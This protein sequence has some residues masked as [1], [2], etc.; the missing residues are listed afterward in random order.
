MKWCP[1]LILAP[2]INAS[3]APVIGIDVGNEYMKIAAIAPGHNLEM[4]LN[5]QSKRKTRS[6]VSFVGAVREF[7]ENAYAQQT[8]HPQHVAQF[9]ASNIAL[10]SQDLDKVKE[11]PNG[12][13]HKYYP[14]SLDKDQEKR[15]TLKMSVHPKENTTLYMEE[16]LA[17][18]LNHGKDLMRTHLKDLSG[19]EDHKDDIEATF[20]IPIH[21]TYRQRQLL[22][23][24]AQIAGFR[25]LAFVYAPMS[26]AL[27]HALDIMDHLDKNSTQ[28]NIFLDSGSRHLQ[29][30]LVKYSYVPA[31]E[32]SKAGIGKQTSKVTDILMVEQLGC[33]TPVS[34]D[35]RYGAHQLDIILADAVVKKSKET[36][37]TARSFRRLLKDVGKL[38]HTLSTNKDSSVNIGEET[39][40]TMTRTEFESLME[41][42]NWLHG[43]GKLKEAI[44]N[45]WK[46]SG[47]PALPME[48]AVHS[49][50]LI[51]GGWR[52]PRVYT[53]IENKFAPLPLGQKV[54]GDESMALGAAMIAANHSTTYKF[55]PLILT[56][57]LNED[58]HVDIFYEDMEGQ[59]QRIDVSF[60]KGTRFGAS[61]KR[62]LNATS[63][64]VKVVVSD[65]NMKVLDMWTIEGID[66]VEKIQLASQAK[67]ERQQALYRNLTKEYQG[68][69]DDL[70]PTW[71]SLDEAEKA[72][73]EK[74]IKIVVTVKLSPLGL[75]QV[76]K[77][78]AGWDELLAEEKD[79]KIASK[80]ANDGSS[81]TDKESENLSET[82]TSTSTQPHAT[83][84][85]GSTVSNG[86]D[87]S[88]P[89]ANESSTSSSTTTS[90]T[91]K[92]TRKIFTERVEKRS[93]HLTSQ[94]MDLLMKDMSTQDL[95]KIQEPLPFNSRQLRDA[96]SALKNF[97]KR[98]LDIEKLNEAR[99]RLEASIYEERERLRSN[100]FIQRVTTKDEREALLKSLGEDEE[101][102]YEEGFNANISVVN[103]RKKDLEN[104]LAK[105]TSKALEVKQREEVIEES[106][107]DIKDM[108]QK[109]SQAQITKPWLTD[110]QISAAKQSLIEFEAWFVEAREKQ[111]KLD[112]TADSVLTK[113]TVRNEWTKVTSSWQKLMKIR[114]PK[115]A[116]TTKGPDD[117]SSSAS[118]RQEL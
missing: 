13:S 50:E 108:N 99:N 71:N 54:N 88:T 36:K 92:R 45:L 40:V 81:T 106:L 84:T 95:E 66:V 3:L 43:I 7:G 9:F 4:I 87:G 69:D 38:K 79:E 118:Q 41:A 23:Q 75:V 83:N 10:K 58:L 82:S 46:S 90:T 57:L 116:A 86:A 47:D 34:E 24:A 6:V 25:T 55:R 11:K 60:E 73:I 96:K 107:R 52:A 102:L 28:H 2:L 17:H 117:T 44:S 100:E 53:E 15:S 26:A 110:A 14:Y 56:Q 111:S 113:E 115:P 112:D 104:R 42:S 78:V 72:K 31:S 94:P 103:K 80:V 39:R 61:R 70:V 74:D 8:M 49:V 76:E 19:L 64:P 101:W 97:V 16:I 114:K 18:L 89:V 29:A 5:T 63:K 109:Y 98:D 51:G 12:F 68:I 62:V 105:V 85:D 30:C 37:L 65:I 20:T 27:S 93:R 1:L 35:G 91:T 32:S 59:P 21:Y 33:V 67:Y 77:A 22:R 48:K